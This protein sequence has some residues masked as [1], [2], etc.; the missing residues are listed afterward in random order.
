MSRKRST[1]AG[2][3]MTARRSPDRFDELRALLNEW[4]PLHTGTRLA[5]ITDEY[6]WLVG[7]LMWQ[8]EHATQPAEIGAWLAQE[9]GREYH[10]RTNHLHIDAFVTRALAWFADFQRR[11]DEW[12][13]SAE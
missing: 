2:S 11:W 3:T 13:W 4:N 12:F 6:D 5:G 8:L 9:L 7:S 1:A 10:M